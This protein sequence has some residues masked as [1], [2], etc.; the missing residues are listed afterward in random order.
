[1]GAMGKKSL[2]AVAGIP[3]T[4]PKKRLIE[5]PGSAQ[6]Q[7][8]AQEHNSHGEHAIPMRQS[9]CLTVCETVAISHTEKGNGALPFAAVLTKKEEKIYTDNSGADD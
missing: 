8:C 3:H 7:H 4:P 2:L 6:G 5:L 1:M 9:E